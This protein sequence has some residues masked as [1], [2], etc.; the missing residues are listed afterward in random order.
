[1]SDKSIVAAILK[2]D[3]KSFE[4]LIIKYQKQLFHTVLS[5][6]KDPD[7]SDD[8]VQEAFLKAFEKLDTLRDKSQFFPWLKRIA[9]N[10]A[11]AH[12]NKS[13]RNVD[14][15]SEWDN[16]ESEKT[17]YF[18]NIADEDNP[19]ELL[20][21]EELRKYVRKFV[22]SLPDRLRVVV[23]LREVEDMSYEEIAETLKIPVGTV[24]SRLFNAR[25]I[26]KNRLISQ[27]LADGLYKIS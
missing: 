17:D 7:I 23:I 19:E 27:G 18:E 11:L 14:M 3:V 15:Y 1:M 22:E 10:L 16:D 6:V 13:K 12:L 24:R 4:L 25:Q 20:L 8:I 9:I 26:I 5:L 21:K 2:G